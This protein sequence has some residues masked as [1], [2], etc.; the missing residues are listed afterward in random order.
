MLVGLAINLLARSLRDRTIQMLKTEEE[1]WQAE[2]RRMEER[3][4]AE[5]ARL[6]LAEL[7]DSSDDA[8]IGKDVHGIVTSWNHGAEMTFGYDAK[9]MISQSIRRLLPSDR[10]S[11]EEVILVL[12]MRGETIKHYETL[13]LTKDHREIDVSLTISPV[14]D[15]QGH[16]VGAS[17]IARDITSRKSLERQLHE[18]MKMEAVGQL[19]GGIA[20]DFNNLLGIVLGNLEMLDDQLAGDEAARSRVQ[21]AYKAAKRGA[22]LTRRL[23]TFSTNEQLLPEATPLAEAIEN[24]VTLASRTLGPD[25]EIQSDVEAGMHCVYV[26]PAGLESALLNLAVNARDAMPHGGSLMISASSCELEPGSAMVQSEG[27][28]PGTLR[29]A[30]GGRHRMRHVR[31]DAGEGLRAVLYHQAAR[32]RDR[33]GAGH[34]LWVC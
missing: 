29:A 26:D 25:I 2:Q 32:P 21:I 3:A 27:L 20:H 19:T 11:E 10:L 12:I 14:R 24:V 15:T 6:R 5:E 30:G 7:V 13:R 31:R 23:L 17:K 28:T 16:V 34:G 22:D 1:L 9:E 8:I 33:T 18:S 4:Q